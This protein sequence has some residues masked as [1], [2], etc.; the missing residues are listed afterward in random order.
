[1]EPIRRLCKSDLVRLNQVEIWRILYAHE[2]IHS[3][4]GSLT[5]TVSECMII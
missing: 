5:L 3:G 2:I 1:M 4:M